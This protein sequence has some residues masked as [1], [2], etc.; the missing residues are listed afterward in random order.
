MV[1]AGI[2]LDKEH[3]VY[4]LCHGEYKEREI[5]ASKHCD[6]FFSFHLNW[7][8]PHGRYGLLLYKKDDE[9]SKILADILAYKFTKVLGYPFKVWALKKGDRGFNNLMYLS[10][11]GIL[12]EPGF[13]NNPEHMRRINGEK[14]GKVLLWGLK[15]WRIQ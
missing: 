14:I 2:I 8:D 1:D 15:K 5:F 13:L 3:T 6:V 11:P 9:K 7:F 10:I 12:L 4:L